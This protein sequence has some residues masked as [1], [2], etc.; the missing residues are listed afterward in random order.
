MLRITANDNRTDHDMSLATQAKPAEE[1]PDQRPST[2][3]ESHA[4][5]RSPNGRIPSVRSVD[6]T[7]NE[8]VPES[9][10][11]LEARLNSEFAMLAADIGKMRKEL[12]DAEERSEQ[13]KH[14]L[15]DGKLLSSRCSTAIA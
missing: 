8:N 13:L 9:F 15:L 4:C 5:E 1:G 3:A 11:A 6:D 7:G 12:R 10:D 2:Q 14:R